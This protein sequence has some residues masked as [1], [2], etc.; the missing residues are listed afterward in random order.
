MARLT[1]LKV[2]EVSLVDKAANKRKFLVYKNEGVSNMN[3]VTLQLNDGLEALFKALAE[4][5]NKDGSFSKYLEAVQK[6]DVQKSLT[7]LEDKDIVTIIKAT[8]DKDAKD[9]LIKVIEKAL[10]LDVIAAILKSGDEVETEIVKAGVSDKAKDA[11]RVAVRAL[12]IAK[13]ELPKDL[14]ATIAKVGNFEMPAPVEVQDPSEIKKNEDGSLDLSGIPKEMRPAVE[15]LW[16]QQE[17]ATVKA[18]ETERVLKAEREERITKEHITKAEGYKNLSVEVDK[19]GPILKKVS[20]A[21]NK[22]E[23]A[24]FDRVLKG[25]DDSLEGFLKEIGSNAG[26]EDADDKSAFGQL[27]KAAEVIAKRDNIT[28]EQAFV[29][30]MDENPDLA[31]KDQEESEAA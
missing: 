13:G 4:A 5:A 19:F 30:A 25:A 31:A 3:E 20:E 9:A 21:L 14:M 29:K 26:N 6:E 11:L 22:D 8:E 1:D 17:A 10:P 18:E 16:K 23:L 27:T 24:E 7:S 28:K 15:Q 12:S 2:I